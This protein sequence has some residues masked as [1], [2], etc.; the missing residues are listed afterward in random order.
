M[1][2]V[3]KYIKINIDQNIKFNK[4]IKNFLAPN[5]VYVPFYKDYE[6]LVKNHDYL[7]MND[8]LLKKGNKTI[9]SPISGEVI[10][11]CDMIVDNKNMKCIVIENDY[12][13]KG[14][15][16]NSRK[17]ILSISKDG[18]MKRVVELNAFSGNLNGDVLLI[19]GIDYEPYE[20]TLN[21]LIYKYTDDILECI[22]ALISI[23][24]VKKCI[25]AIKNNNSENVLKLINQIG[26]YPDITLKLIND[27]YPLGMKEVL[28]K[29]LIDKKEGPIV[30]DVN[31]VYNIYN[32]LRKDK[33]ITH[34]LVTF[35][36]NLLNKSKVINCKLGTNISEI[37]EEEFNIKDS[38][39]DIVINGLLS[40]YKV[41]NSNVCITNNIRSVFVVKPIRCNTQECINCGNCL[42]YCPVG[43]NPKTG[44]KMEKC[45]K[46]GL[47][48]YICPANINLGGSHE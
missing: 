3:S 32:V 48:S 26:T 16:I 42:N 34:K 17:N 22:S 41:E 46:C 24:K 31:D 38:N 23:L 8:V 10:G 1:I 35:S 18:L 19:T 30:L 37:L 21:S 14:K 7:T 6:L 40:G 20:N 4:E 36:G 43:A 5:Y 27:L 45:I 29:N 11:L 47:C 28:V 12:M 33:P 13:E 9:Y 15:I 2:K 39:Y 25:L 44:Y